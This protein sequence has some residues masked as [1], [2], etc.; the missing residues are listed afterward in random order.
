MTGLTLLTLTMTSAVV[1]YNP[2]EQK[3][4]WRS[5]RSRLLVLEVMMAQ[6]V[7]GR[8]EALEE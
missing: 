4:A 7:Y 5:V 3:M 6:G 8:R 2:T 1:M